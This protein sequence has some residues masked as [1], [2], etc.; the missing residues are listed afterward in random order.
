MQTTLASDVPD[1]RRQRFDAAR[2]RLLAVPISS[3]TSLLEPFRRIV[4]IAAITLDVQR[5]AIWLFSPDRRSLRCAAQY[6]SEV[7]AHSN[8]TTLH[9]ADFPAYFAALAQ[10]RDIPAEHVLEDPRTAELSEAYLVP[11]GITSLLDA[12]IFLH[13]KLMG[14]VCHEQIVKPRKWLVDEREFVRAVADAVAGQLQTDPGDLNTAGHTVDMN[15]QSAAMRQTAAGIGHDFRNLLTVIQGNVGLLKRRPNMT[16]ADRELLATIMN[17]AERGAGLANELVWCGM[18]EPQPTRVIVATEVVHSLLDVLR[19]AARENH[20][21]EFVPD[22]QQARVFIN[23]GQ[24]ERVLMNLVINARDASPNSG[25]IR[26]SVGQEETAPQGPVKSAYIR[27]EV[28]DFGSGIDQETLEHIFD[29][30]FTTKAKG[31]GSGL[32]L[33]VVKQLAERAG[34]FVTVETELGTGTSFRVYLPRVSARA[35]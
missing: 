22:P 17:A 7:G 5:T 19:A 2:D 28:R 15:A 10:L 34:G 12:P 27:I 6:E 25:V 21:I 30:F 24:L 14:V 29:P 20:Q 18:N 9:V 16:A 33:A 1:E 26:V 3:G 31:Q 23:P 8:G 13:G 35:N 4:E 11:L 32:G